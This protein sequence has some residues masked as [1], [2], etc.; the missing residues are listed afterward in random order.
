[1]TSKRSKA[2]EDALR[3]WPPHLRLAARY[4]VVLAQSSD[5]AL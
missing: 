4:T 3:H 2:Q 1:M 5:T